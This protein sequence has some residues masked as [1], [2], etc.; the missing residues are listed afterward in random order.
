MAANEYV[1]D[2]HHQD[3]EFMRRPM[4]EELF[5]PTSI[6]HPERTEMREGWCCLDSGAEAGY[7]MRWMPLLISRSSQLHRY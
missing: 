5:D 6:E 3:H 7:I 2:E 4:I 1:I